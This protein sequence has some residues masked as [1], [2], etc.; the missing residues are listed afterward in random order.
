MLYLLRHWISTHW[1][2]IS[3]IISFIL[4]LVTALMA[5]YT[6]EMAKQTKNVRDDEPGWKSEILKKRSQE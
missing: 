3:S 6:R 4:A 1:A 5:I 2:A